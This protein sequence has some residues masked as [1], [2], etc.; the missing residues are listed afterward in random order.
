MRRLTRQF[1][2]IKVRHLIMRRIIKRRIIERR[3]CTIIIL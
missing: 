3:T 2:E 1:V